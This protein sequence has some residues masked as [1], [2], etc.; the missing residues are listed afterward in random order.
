MNL[1]NKKLINTKTYYNRIQ[2]DAISKLSIFIEFQIDRETVLVLVL[3]LL[4]Y[5]HSAK[6]SA[7][8]IASFVELE[9]K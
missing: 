4:V 1:F 6:R 5:S 3:T 8:H 9:R 2:N 7:N